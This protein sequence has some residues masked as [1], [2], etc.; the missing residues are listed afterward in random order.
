MAHS[1]EDYD[2]DGV[3]IG[4][5]VQAA[6]A[7]RSGGKPKMFT[8][9]GAM[10]SMDIN[11]M[12]GM[13]GCVYKGV[14]LVPD[15][16]ERCFDVVRGCE[17]DN[18]NHTV[19]VDVKMVNAEEREAIK[20]SANPMRAASRT[21]VDPVKLG[22]GS[23][24]QLLMMQDY[25]M[26]SGDFWDLEIG[27][28]VR[29]EWA[30]ASKDGDSARRGKKGDVTV[31]IN[32][33]VV[34]A[35]PVLMSDST[36]GHEQT[37]HY[38][39]LPGSKMPWLMALFASAGQR[40]T[41]LRAPV[42]APGVHKPA[43]REEL[44]A[45]APKPSD[46]S[47]ACQ[48]MI[49]TSRF[50]IPLLP[51]SSA[52]VWR[53]PLQAGQTTV[54]WAAGTGGSFPR[55]IKDK[56]SGVVTEIG[57]TTFN[58]S[59]TIKHVRHPGLS[60]PLVTDEQ[61]AGDVQGDD[62]DPENLPRARL[63]GKQLPVWFMDGEP[64]SAEVTVWLRH[65]SAFG[66][67]NPSDVMSGCFKVLAPR[68]PALVSTYMSQSIMT[69][70]DAEPK[71]D[72]AFNLAFCANSQMKIMKKDDPKREAERRKKC[73][74]YED[75]VSV[76]SVPALGICSVGAPIT[77][78]AAMAI[79]D[80]RAKQFNEPQRGVTQYDRNMRL[81]VRHYKDGSTSKDVPPDGMEARAVCNAF[82]V[83]H[84]KE[85]LMSPHKS[86]TFFQ[87]FAVF[88][89]FTKS[90][91]DLP[92]DAASES[93]NSVI[94]T[95]SATEF[96]LNL[97]AEKGKDEAQRVMGSIAVQIAETGKVT[98]P[99]EAV[100]A[101]AK[102][103]GVERSNVIPFGVSKA[104][105]R[106]AGIDIWSADPVT[107]LLERGMNEVYRGKTVPIN[108]EDLKKYI[109][110]RTGG[111]SRPAAPV[112]SASGKPGKRHEPTADAE[113]DDDQDQAPPTKKRHEP[114][115]D[116]EPDDDQDQAPPAKDKATDAADA[117]PAD[118][119]TGPAQF[120]VSMVDFGTE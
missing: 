56:D 50:Y 89:C 65:V 47:A 26:Q 3:D 109:A 84:S 17:F 102:P 117:K 60:L 98:S 83:T 12:Q 55:K 16:P 33:K 34:A 66:I 15:V 92:D 88:D 39:C 45:A 80:A 4:R 82:C 31:Q 103:E 49:R 42:L 7:A 22:F 53:A 105:I 87:Y 69:I 85:N 107:P 62:G 72:E 11:A 35:R 32:Y 90:T 91:V 37:L 52:S 114:T 119:D 51:T 115:A 112:A 36:P 43:N 120:D 79:I 111:S 5:K 59:G 44:K 6:R 29:D 18:V 106:S 81:A 110:E 41:P 78:E 104:W 24:M 77:H 20:A 97:V 99:P 38:S 73:F 2:W 68:T 40:N 63:T 14:A 76:F 30:P 27:E 48:D 93:K 116:A 118:S 21:S 25:G 57:S 54:M 70:R 58:V 46:Y 108:T 1:G 9:K 95:N 96:F 74:S 75:N 86:E 10:I 19:T 28:V 113:P 71:K 8:I 101:F 61:R 64:F 67:V 100:L 94:A 23:E 13:K